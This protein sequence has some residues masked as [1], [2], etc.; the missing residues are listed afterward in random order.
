MTYKEMAI[1]KLFRDNIC[2]TDVS[3][4][5]LELH[6]LLKDVRF[7]DEQF[8]RNRVKPVL[9]KRALWFMRDKGGLF[10]IFL[11]AQ[12]V[13]DVFSRLIDGVKL[14]ESQINGLCVWTVE[15][16]KPFA[17]T[18]RQRILEVANDIKRNG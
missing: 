14:S 10:R 4:T 15:L 16:I 18:W 11:S 17:K 1:E 5:L 7:I 6:D 12:D 3:Y 8:L 2:D 9:T 13:V